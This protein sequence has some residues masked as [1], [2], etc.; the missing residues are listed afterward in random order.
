MNIQINR[1]SETPIYLQ[2]KKSIKKLIVN[3]ELTEGYKLPPERKLAE[4]LQV[5][6]NTVVKAYCELIADGLVTASREKPKGYFVKSFANEDSFNKRFFPLE[7]M[8]KYNFNNKEKL[9]LD[10][11]SD[12]ADKNY[13]SLGGITMDFDM[14]PTDGMKE[15]VSSMFSGKM[16]SVLHTLSRDEGG[17]TRENI[18]N[19]L[20]KE[21]M[22][23]NPRNIQLVSETNQALNYLM[24]L[25]LEEGESVIVEEPI[26]PD[27]ASVFRNKHLN[28]VT[29][30]M[31]ED[32]M[33]VELLE[34][35]IKQYNP[36]FIYTMPNYHNPTGITMSL[37]KRNRLLEIAQN[38]GVPIIEE[39][40]QRDFRYTDNRL[41]SLYTLDRY[42]SVIYID[43][44]TLT[45]PYSIKTGYI[46]APY[47][48]VEMIGRLIVVDE[49]IVSNMG[50]FILNEYIEG[51]YFS[52]HV[53]KLAVYYKAKRDLLC[54]ELD[55]I[56]N[57]GIN[58]NKPE[59]G[60]L[61]WCTLDAE[62]NER[63][64]FQKAEKKRIINYAR[65]HILS[66]WT[67]RKWPYKIM[68]FKH[69]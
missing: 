7:K 14:I 48:V 56:R 63:K 4:E 5:H 28:I 40:S 32:G 9:F 33:K 65:I 66:R 11:F 19:I 6:R 64:L 54:S 22:Y 68:F 8:M 61:L 30:P 58:Y 45:F 67:C 39:D 3:R 47:D 41:P 12:S 25:Y 53:E 69:Q 21:N 13:I 27:N 16:G 26:V 49:T 60:L 57:K 37:D 23:V 10:I 1:N 44:F 62:I 29:V 15:I 34:K 18:C 36:K 52:K 59:G 17:R 24:T 35:L 50:Q 46:V 51:G 55:K 20:S 43:S 31:E 38:Y 42:K 2:I